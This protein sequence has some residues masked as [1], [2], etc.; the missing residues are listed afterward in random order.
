VGVWV[1][2]AIGLDPTAEAVY[3]LVLSRPELEVDELAAQ[4]ELS[5]DNVRQAIASL[6]ALKLLRKEGPGEDLELVDPDVGLAALLARSEAELSARQRQIE[7]TRSAVNTIAAQYSSRH[8]HSRDGVRQ[9]IGRDAVRARLEELARENRFECLAFVTGGAQPAESIEAVKP[10]DQLALER[11]VQFR[12]IYQESFR[13]DPGTLQHVGWMSS[14]G[15][16]TRTVPSLP[17]R[18]IIVDREAAVLPLDPL[19]SSKGAMEMRNPGLVAT[20]VVLFEQFWEAATPW[21]EPP[22]QDK[23]GLT[24]RER[25]ILTMLAIGHTDDWIARRLGLSLRTVRRVI[26]DLMGRLDARS[27]FE[28]GVLAVRSGWL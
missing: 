24:R 22:P 5:A 10:V 13:N 28:A 12:N 26:A 2:E 6:Q 11:G 8:E 18:M 14:L 3:R 20:M 1:F 19:D 23:F 21:T 17:M 4:L 25:E 27:R 7:A 16:Q 9:L 15:G